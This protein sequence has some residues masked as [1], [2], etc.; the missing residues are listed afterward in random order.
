[1]FIIGV[2]MFFV[3]AV[4][5]TIGGLFDIRRLF[6]VLHEQHAE[7]LKQNAQNTDYRSPH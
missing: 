4:V 1:M 7:Y 6:R 3:L 5:V 2:G